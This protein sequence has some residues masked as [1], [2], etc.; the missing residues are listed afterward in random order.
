MARPLNEKTVCAKFS[1]KQVSQNGLPHLDEVTFS[2]IEKMI[3][4]KYTSLGRSS[5]SSRRPEKLHCLQDASRKSREP[6]TTFPSRRWFP[7]DRGDTKRLSGVTKVT[8]AIRSR[9]VAWYPARANEKRGRARFIIARTRA[10]G[11]L[12]RSLARLIVS[13]APG[14][15]GA[16]GVLER[17][18]PAASAIRL[19]RCIIL[20]TG[21]SARP[22]C[23]HQ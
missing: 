4:A 5:A 6:H 1:L 15:T 19:T 18:S 14:F 23:G 17:G 10:R 21:R 8:N 3:R 13:S 20:P 7:R 12:S 16:S 2:L 22:V 11:Y 9:D